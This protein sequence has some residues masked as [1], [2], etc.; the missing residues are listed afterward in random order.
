LLQVRQ[1]GNPLCWLHYLQKREFVLSGSDVL[2]WRFLHLFDGKLM[3][4]PDTRYAH[5]AMQESRSLLRIQVGFPCWTAALIASQL[6]AFQSSVIS[7][8]QVL[9][10]LH[11]EPSWTVAFLAYEGFSRRVFPI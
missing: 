1:L 4:L 7:H 6:G 9:A 5:V 8:L 3:Q 2:F 11:I 10:V